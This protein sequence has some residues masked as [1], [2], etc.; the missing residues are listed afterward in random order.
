MTQ[1]LPLYSIISLTSIS[2]PHT[3]VAF[4]EVNDRYLCPIAGCGMPLNPGLALSASITLS[5]AFI[6]FVGKVSLSTEKVKNSSLFVEL[7]VPIISASRLS[8]SP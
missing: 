2:R 7:N 8:I 1:A 5:T 3:L 4:V 6:V